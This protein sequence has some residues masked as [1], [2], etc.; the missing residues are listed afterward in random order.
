VE[1]VVFLSVRILP[2]TPTILNEVFLDF[3]QPHYGDAG[4]L[5]RLGHEPFQFNIQLTSLPLD[6]TQYSPDARSVVS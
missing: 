1:L 5:P 2:G 3:P 6:P 4:T